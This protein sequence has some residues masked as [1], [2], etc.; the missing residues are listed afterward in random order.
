MSPKSMNIQ[1]KQS[2]EFNLPRYFVYVQRDAFLYPTELKIKLKC[3]V[4]G[5]VLEFSHLKN[6]LKK[7]HQK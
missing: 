5:Q 6:D 3:L 4:W 7:D 2:P 1:I